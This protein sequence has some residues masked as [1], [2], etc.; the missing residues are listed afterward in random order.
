MANQAGRSARAEYERRSEH[1]RANRPQF[2]VALFKILLL[3]FGTYVVVHLAAA[4][5]NHVLEGLEK[6]PGPKTTSTTPPFSDGLAN[7][8]GMLFAVLAG[9]F[10]AIRIWAPRQSTVAWRQGAEGEERLGY[11]LDQLSDEGF[12][13]FHDRRVPASRA[14]VDH[15][16]IGPTGVFVVDAK[17]FNY[18]LS[19]SKGILWTGKYPVKLSNTRN[20]AQRVEDALA[21]SLLSRPLK[22]LP[23]ICVVG[24]ARLPHRTINVEGVRVVSDWRTLEAEILGHRTV[25][26][27]AEVAALSRGAEDRL[28]PR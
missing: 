9:A 1:D 19:L 23:F 14:N 16:V 26:T 12:V 13:V 4:L 25:L 5:F 18:D 8:F 24:T 21:S 10:G 7:E 11:W 27:A 2:P 15:L 3:A 6:M 20:Q 17:N 28:L 22:V